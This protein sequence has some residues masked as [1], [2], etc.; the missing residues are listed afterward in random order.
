MAYIYKI[1]NS[2]NKKIYVGK[3]KNAVSICFSQHKTDSKNPRM[4][5]T[6]L[7][8]AMQK[9]GQDNFIVEVLEECPEKILNEREKF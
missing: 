5:H 7:Y 3:T 1:T 8:R 9:Y 6:H 4:N 2:I